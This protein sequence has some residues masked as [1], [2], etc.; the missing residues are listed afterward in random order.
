PEEREAE[1]LR[2]LDELRPRLDVGRGS[3]PLEQQ[4]LGVRLCRIVDERHEVEP[5]QL[6]PKSLGLC[7][8]PTVAASRARGDYPKSKLVD[9][10]HLHWALCFGPPRGS[11]GPDMRVPSGKVKSWP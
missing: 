8:A 11:W 1:I 6:E 10:V 4:R 9:L 7:H 2:C 3:A 5:G